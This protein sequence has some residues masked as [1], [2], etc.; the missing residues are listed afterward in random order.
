LS[1]HVSVVNVTE[2]RYRI[3]FF[4]VQSDPVKLYLM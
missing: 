2:L 3:S 1:A 4:I